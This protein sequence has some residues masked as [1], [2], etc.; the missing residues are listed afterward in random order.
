MPGTPA[1]SQFS[2][3]D[4]MGTPLPGGVWDLPGPCLHPYPHQSSCGLF[5]SLVVG[6]VLDDGS[7]IL[8]WSLVVSSV[9]LRHLDQSLDKVLTC[10][11]SHKSLIVARI[12]MI[13]LL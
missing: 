12:L 13:P 2:Q 9:A 1:A 6:L 8:M 4:A 10:T 5:I 3:P 7:V 11:F